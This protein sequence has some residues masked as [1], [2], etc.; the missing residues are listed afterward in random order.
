MRN[1]Y[2]LFVQV[3]INHNTDTGVHY[4]H[5]SVFSYGVEQYNTNIR[6]LL[7]DE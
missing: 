4:T 1:S 2:K 5:L 7:D 3:F 6:E